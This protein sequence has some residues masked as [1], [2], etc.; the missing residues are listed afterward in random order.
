MRNDSASWW[1]VDSMSQAMTLLPLVKL[2]RVSLHMKSIPI[3]WLMG[4]ALGRDLLS[5]HFQ[6]SSYSKYNFVKYIPY[7]F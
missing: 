7:L 6:V 5:L 2:E 4:Y 1:P 3:K